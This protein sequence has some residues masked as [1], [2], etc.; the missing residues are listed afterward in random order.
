VA[1]NLAH[2]FFHRAAVPGRSQAQPA[3]QV[4]VEATDK[5]GWHDIDDSMD[6]GDINDIYILQS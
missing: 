1:Q 4:V 5:E 2:F 3:L 6:I